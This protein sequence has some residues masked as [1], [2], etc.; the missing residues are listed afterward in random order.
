MG[1]NG[2]YT[3][4]V[5]RDAITVIAHPG[6]ETETRG[7]W[8]GSTGTLK[9]DLVSGSTVTF[10]AVPAGCELKIQVTRVYLTGT[11]AD[12]IVALYLENHW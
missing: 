6:S 9:V 12:S 8:I 2:L 11:S 5:T 7:L 10:T 4:A 3:V 1:G